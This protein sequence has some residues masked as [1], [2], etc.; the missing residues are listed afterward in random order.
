MTF[1]FFPGLFGY[2]WIFPGAGVTSLGIG[3]RGKQFKSEEMFG[4]WEKMLDNQPELA[5]AKAHLREE[6]VSCLIPALRFS[7]LRN[8]KVVGGN[9]ALIG[10]ASGAAQ[11]VS[12]GGIH[13]AFKTADLLA[14]ALSAETPGQYQQ[15]WWR[16]AK[17][18][19]AGP[20]LW[21]N[22]FYS[23]RMQKMLSGYLLTSN[24]ARNLV[25]RLISG[26]RPSRGE[27]ISSL[28]KMLLG[29]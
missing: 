6:A 4:L 28:T 27:I 1:K 29:A 14:S 22:L 20:A 25:A 9:W 8:Q 2:G 13:F 7:T 15:A 21:G 5:D 26:E 24:S 23:T 16:M 3:S 17:K 18:E 10:D 12:G 11:A 19:L